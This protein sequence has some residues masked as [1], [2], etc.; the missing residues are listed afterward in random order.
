M[1]TVNRQIIDT[2]GYV[3]IARGYV[4]DGDMGHVFFSAEKI[5]AAEQGEYNNQHQSTPQTSLVALWV[6]KQSWVIG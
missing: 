5:L 2:H 1:V 4:I 6:D 3:K